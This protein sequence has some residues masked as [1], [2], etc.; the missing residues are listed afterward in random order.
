MFLNYLLTSPEAKYDAA[1]QRQHSSA[2]DTLDAV[3]AVDAER[4]TLSWQNMMLQQEAA[5]L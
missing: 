1:T 5:Y 4:C 3:T 2:A